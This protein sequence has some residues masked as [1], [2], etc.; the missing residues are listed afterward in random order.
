M[1]CWAR[2]LGK[3]RFAAVV[4]QCQERQAIRC[5]LSCQPRYC[6]WEVH[7]LTPGQR[8]ALYT[9]VGLDTWGAYTYLPTYLALPWVPCLGTPYLDCL[10]TREGG[11]GKRRGGARTSGWRVTPQG[12]LRYLPTVGIA[13]CLWRCAS[14][15][16]PS[17]PR[18]CVR[19]CV[20]AVRD[21]GGD[22][23]GAAAS[24]GA[25]QQ[26]PVAIDVML[27]VRGHDAPRGKDMLRG[28]T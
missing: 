26:S 24:D 4:G 10:G 16:L 9:C 23:G 22:G 25:D 2:Y 11:L 18:V 7:R 19:V 14:P 15:S 20:R 6:Y 1:C 17:R 27:M 8:I 13:G 21:R 12:L 3:T 5:A 28:R